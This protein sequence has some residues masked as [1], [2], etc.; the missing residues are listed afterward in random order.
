MS[1]A[2]ALHL[3]TLLIP[4]LVHPEMPFVV[5]KKKKKRPSRTKHSASSM[6]KR[7]MEISG[8]TG[9]PVLRVH[10]PSVPHIDSCFEILPSVSHF[11]SPAPSWNLF[12]IRISLL[13]NFSEIFLSFP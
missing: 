2:E 1:Y 9:N 4:P 7:G 5:K 10:P 6:P 12:I 13:P 8:S 3:I 11:I